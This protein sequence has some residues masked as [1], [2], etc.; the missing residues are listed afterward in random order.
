M[1]ET[2]NGD[3]GTG[4]G[5]IR[6]CGV[7]ACVY[8]C[9]PHVYFKNGPLQVPVERGQEERAVRVVSTRAEEYRRP[10]PHRRRHRLDQCCGLA[11][12]P[13]AGSGMIGAAGHH[14]HTCALCQ[15]RQRQT[16]APTI[17]ACRLS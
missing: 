11:R 6:E 16:H 5:I 8:V 15:A 3:N 1:K 10:P 12:G 4:L 7:R 17:P 9:C 2:M 14:A 13:R